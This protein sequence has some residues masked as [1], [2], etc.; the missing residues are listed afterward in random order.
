[1]IGNSKNPE[2]RFS[3]FNEAW[4]VRT[5]SQIVNDIS[6]GDWIE[7]DH[8]FERGEYRIIQTG[9]LDSNGEFKNN[10]NTAK[11]FHQ[12][13]FDEIRANE[14]YPGDILISRLAEPAG[15]TII[16]PDTN[17]R[18]VT[19]VDVT[20]I[21][22][23]K[24]FDSYFLKTSSNR[25][26]VLKRVA[27]NVAGTSH[28]R[29]S[30]RNLE[31][32]EHL[33]PTLNEQ[34]QIGSFF[35]NLDNQINLK[36]SKLD[37]LITLKKAMLEKIFPKE[38][39]NEPEIRFKGFSGAWADCLVSEVCSI[40]TGKNNT[41]D[42]VQD[43]KYPFYVRSSVIERSHNY[44]FEQEAVLTVGDGVGTGKVYHYVNGKYDLHQRVY[45][46]FDFNG[47]VG[48]YFYHYFSNHFN[49]RVN[50]MTA[51]TSVDSVRLEMIAEMLIQIPSE[52]EQKLIVQYLDSL[53]N[54]IT[55]QKTELTK[56]KQIKASCLEKMFV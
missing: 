56:L 12:K 23:D 6:D 4:D 15:R 39:A 1:M 54:L 5:L 19:S 44:L 27:E 17:S 41:Q 31:K 28:K 49:D 30:R 34:S 21:R 24:S 29:I 33:V 42:K 26:S 14:I 7:S 52:E 55:L 11:Y 18:M 45:R 36:Q 43:G 32:T 51:K 22:P 20:V 10:P 16:L 25:S 9:N 50:E 3:G 46:M 48:K 47:V 13:D 37:K 8:I 2:I 35:K 40:S 38:G 53:D